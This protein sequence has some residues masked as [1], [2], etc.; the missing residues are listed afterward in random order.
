MQT[1]ALRYV[2]AIK[3]PREINSK[4]IKYQGDQTNIF[5]A[6]ARQTSPIPCDRL[7]GTLHVT[8]RWMCIHHRP[9]S[10]YCRDPHGHAKYPHVDHNSY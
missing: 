8:P 9:Q 10:N 4:E 3:A 5:K 2:A 7:L 6:D 1:N